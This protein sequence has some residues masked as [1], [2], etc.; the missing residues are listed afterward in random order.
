MTDDRIKQIEDNAIEYRN[1]SFRLNPSGFH[2]SPYCNE[3]SLSNAF[4]AGAEFAD[5]NPTTEDQHRRFLMDRKLYKQ[6]QSDRKI[7]VEALDKLA[8]MGGDY[9]ETVARKAL[10]AIGEE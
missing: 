8:R 5:S 4:Q 3:D 7:L 6:L 2:V 10:K 1:E 9:E